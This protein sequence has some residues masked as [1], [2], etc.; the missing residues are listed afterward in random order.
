MAN[1][2]CLS[3]VGDVRAPYSGGLTFRGY[4]ASY[5]SLAIR[6][7][8]HQ[9]SRISSK[10]ITPSERVKQE[11]GGQTGESGISPHIVTFGCLIPWWVVVLYL[12]VPSFI[13]CHWLA[14]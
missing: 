14:I 1:P 8:T 7:L 10:G 13:L 4:F 9:K 6:Q 2:S 12:P 3:V 5:C 11:G